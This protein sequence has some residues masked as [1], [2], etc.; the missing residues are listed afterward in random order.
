MQKEGNCI[1]KIH[2]AYLI[3]GRESSWI[4][5]REKVCSTTNTEFK[6]PLL[7][8]MATKLP[9]HTSQLC[10]NVH[11]LNDLF[12]R[13]YLWILHLHLS[14]QFHYKF[15][16]RCASAC[17][18]SLLPLTL[19]YWFLFLIWCRFKKLVVLMVCCSFRVNPLLSNLYIY[20]FP[21]NCFREFRF[22]HHNNDKTGHLSTQTFIFLKLSTSGY[23]SYLSENFC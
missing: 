18:P 14:Q 5:H 8:V 19:P 1:A 11:T 22:M 3:N 16:S 2:P 13:L 9:G 12:Q 21:G 23:S 4:K 15:T 7:W 6:Y 17:Q 20:N 10:G